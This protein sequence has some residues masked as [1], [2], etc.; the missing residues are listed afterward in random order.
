MPFQEP[1]IVTPPFPEYVS[2][3]STFSAAG[4]Y[5]LQ[6]VTG[7]DLFVDSYLAEP[8]SSHIEPGIT[9]MLAVVLYW[10]TLSSAADQAGLSRRYGGIHFQ[11]GDLD[12]RALGRQVAANGWSKAQSYINCTA[13]GNDEYPFPV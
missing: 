12:A 7:F 13:T 10:P 8:G 4:A 6:Q 9:P 1:T 2:G 3:H 5:I 11:Q